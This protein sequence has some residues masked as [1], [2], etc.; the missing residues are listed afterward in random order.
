[1][2]CDK[3]M[4]PRKL[5]AAVDFGSTHAVARIYNKNCESVSYLP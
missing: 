3:K 1:M 2:T 4:P 5:I